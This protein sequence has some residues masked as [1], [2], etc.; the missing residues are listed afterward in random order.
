LSK[1]IS[2]HNLGNVVGHSHLLVK[3]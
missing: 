1:V 3:T 2:A